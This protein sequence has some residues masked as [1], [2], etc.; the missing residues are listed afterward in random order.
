MTLGDA[1]D[2]LVHCPDENKVVLGAPAFIKGWLIAT[3]L[4][5]SVSYSSSS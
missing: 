4:W 2:P 3:T 1:A 5:V